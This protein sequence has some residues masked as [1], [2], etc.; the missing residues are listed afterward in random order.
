MIDEI[1]KYIKAIKE[2]SDPEVQDCANDL[3]KIVSGVDCLNEW[4][5]IKIAKY[6][7]IDTETSGLFDFNKPADAE[8]QPRMAS[9][10]MIYL[11][12]TLSI[13]KESMFYIKPEGWSMNEEA[14]K[15]N[16]LTDEILNEKGISVKI[17]LDEYTQAIKDGLIIVA[18]NAQYDTK[19]LRAELRRAG[20]EDLFEKTFNICMMK[21]TMDILKIPGRYG[22]FKWPKLSEAAQYFGI[23]QLEAHTAL[24]DTRVTVLVM[25]KVV[26]LNLLPE[27]AVN[28]AKKIPA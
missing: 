19:I 27:P 18:F 4:W 22:S 6:L 9:V 15:I 5:N 26:D 21:A 2:S 7:V 16:G 8:G 11:D 28:Y 14:S 24:D 25:R 13:T 10:A 1:K 3:E 23:E 17:V 12:E 20:M